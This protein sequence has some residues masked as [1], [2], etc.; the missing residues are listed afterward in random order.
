MT[1]QQYT[2]MLQKL[3]NM[4]WANMRDIWPNLSAYKCPKIVACGRLTRTAGK[5]Y[6]TTRIIHIGYKF[7]QHSREYYSEV[8]NVILPHELIHIA[9]FDL[10]G[11]SDLPCGH[12]KTWRAMMK[13]YGLPAN[14]FHK[15]DLKT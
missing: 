8:V 3:A 2:I 13:E 15:M 11:E 14:K 1:K 9:D 7:L 5:A 6:Q 10:F 12:G 4:Q